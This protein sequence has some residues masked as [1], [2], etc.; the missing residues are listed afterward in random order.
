MLQCA[1]LLRATPSLG[2]F[3]S[4]Q[5]LNSWIGPEFFTPSTSRRGS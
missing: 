1:P 5:G 4:Q 2:T 3:S